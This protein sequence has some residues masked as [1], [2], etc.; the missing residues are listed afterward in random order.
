M[1]T[2]QEKREALNLTTEAAIR[3]AILAA[4]LVACFHIILPFLLPV[5]WGIII[6]IAVWPIV[7]RMTRM[8]G[9]RQ[10]TAAALFTVLAIALLLIPSWLLAENVTEGLVEAGSMLADDEVVIP[11]PPDRIADW[12][13]VGER[14]AESWA[15]AAENPPA[16]IAAHSDQIIAFGKYLLGTVADLGFGILQ[17]VFAIILAG[18]FLTQSNGGTRALDALALRLAGEE[19]GHELL[20]TAGDTVSSVVKGVLGVAAV[21]AVAAWIG[22]AIAGVP[23]SA[24]W[25]LAVLVLAIMQLPPLL[26]LAPIIF[27]VFATTGT[28]GAVVFMIWSLLVGVSDG[29]LKPLFLGR[30]VETPMLVI[31]IG[32]IGGLIAWGILGLFVGAVVLAL[33]WELGRVWFKNPE[34]SEL[35]EATVQ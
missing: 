30:G 1:H 32:A 9:G 4:L 31:L 10:K 16:A 18:V 29:F 19:R 6:A 22:M 13:L 14:L 5:I 28:T 11:P 12:P 2:A 3:L 26:V 33:G 21:Q 20:K 23:Y 35:P 15:E 17:F 7:R 8:L 25:A 24:A 34:F 27:Y